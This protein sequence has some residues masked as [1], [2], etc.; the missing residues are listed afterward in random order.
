[1]RTHVKQTTGRRNLVQFIILLLHPILVPAKLVSPSS[2]PL[3]TMCL[4]TLW[5]FPCIVLLYY[6]GFTLWLHR[7][8]A[9]AACLFLSIHNFLL[10]LP[11]IIDISWLL[12][13]GNSRPARTPPHQRWLLAESQIRLAHF[14]SFLCLPPV[15][16]SNHAEGK[17]TLVCFPCIRSFIPLWNAASN[18]ARLQKYAFCLPQVPFHFHLPRNWLMLK[19]LLTKLC[20]TSWVV[21]FMLLFTLL[22]GISPFP[23]QW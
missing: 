4:F 23:A 9:A 19:L 20:I 3:P 10:T 1:M 15:H 18:E 11:S 5:C 17:K 12:T 7:I 14:T 8:P 16:P 13:T 21:C 2:L 22:A 6:L